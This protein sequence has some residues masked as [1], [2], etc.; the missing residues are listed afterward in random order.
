M[1]RAGL[2]VRVVGGLA[3][4]V[5]FVADGALADNPLTVADH[6]SLLG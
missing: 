2:R 4:T 5:S 6:S 3:D 1:R